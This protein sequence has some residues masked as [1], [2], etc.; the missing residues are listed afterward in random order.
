MSFDFNFCLAVKASMLLNDFESKEQ[1]RDFLDVSC[2]DKDV[3]SV[4][5][6]IYTFE[7]GS[8]LCCDGD[9]VKARTAKDSKSESLH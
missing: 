4:D 9:S 5:K 2:V 1:C 7:D 3:L 8:F 6:V